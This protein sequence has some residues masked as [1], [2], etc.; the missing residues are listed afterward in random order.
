MQFCCC[1]GVGIGKA[2]FVVV[3]EYGS[4]RQFLLFGIRDREGSFCV[5]WA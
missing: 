4:G 5:V 2:F 1:F 3:W